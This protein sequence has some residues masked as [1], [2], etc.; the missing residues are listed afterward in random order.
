LIVIAGLD[1]AIHRQEILSRWMRGSSPRMTMEDRCHQHNL[2]QTKNAKLNFC[3]AS[4]RRSLRVPQDSLCHRCPAH[5][6]VPSGRPRALGHARFRA[7]PGI[8]VSRSGFRRGILKKRS[9]QQKTLRSAR[10]GRVQDRT[11]DLAT[12]DHSHEPG[13]RYRSADGRSTAVQIFRVRISSSRSS[14][15]ANTMFARARDISLA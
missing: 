7:S 5:R 12:R 2:R 10:L 14:S 8:R 9:G 3:G 1:P 11:V 6:L 4:S 13:M 15:H